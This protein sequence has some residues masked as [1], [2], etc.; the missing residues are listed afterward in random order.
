MGY[1]LVQWEETDIE[2]LETCR[3]ADRKTEK[4]KQETKVISLVWS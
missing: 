1:I 3:C 4:C 2:T